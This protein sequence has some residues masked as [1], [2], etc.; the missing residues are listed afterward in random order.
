MVNIK[1]EKYRYCREAEFPVKEKYKCLC[2]GI[3][4]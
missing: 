1:G 4:V 2:V 3:L